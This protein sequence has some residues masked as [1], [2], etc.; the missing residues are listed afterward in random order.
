MHPSTKIKSVAAIGMLLSSVIM[1][2]I[3]PSCGTADIEGSDEVTEA[4]SEASTIP[5]AT[6]TEAPKGDEETSE[7]PDAEPSEDEVEE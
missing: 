4:P 5:E 7:E 3:V 6:A 1:V 2:A